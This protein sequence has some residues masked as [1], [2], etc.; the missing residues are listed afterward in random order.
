MSVQIL[1]QPDDE[2]CGP[3]S[4]HAVY[5]HFNYNIEL[6]QLISDTT[7]L[8]AGGTLAVY[9]GLDALKRGFKANIYSCN[10][11]IFDP[12]WADLDSTD[13]I[14][15]LKEQLRYKDGKKI[16]QASLAYINFL[17][18]GGQVH[19]KLIEPNLI[20]QLLKNGTPLLTG[21][22]ATYLYQTK[23]EYVAKNKT[24]SFNDTRGFSTGHFVVLHGIDENNKVR[25][26]D[27]YGANPI[28]HSNY[29]NVDMQR[30]INAIHLG[31]ITYD[32]NI[33]IIEK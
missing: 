25:V 28:N 22:N 19:L 4:L 30:L 20:K 17:E 29:Y 2:T 6:K 15:K 12:T 18:Q 5:Q 26:A 8:K 11:S 9:L 13:L 21:L 31:I 14:A 1:S 7:F 27:P 32:A 33:L 23:R 3:T 16:T 10:L 24:S